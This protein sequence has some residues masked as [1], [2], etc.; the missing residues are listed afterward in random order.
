[1]THAS[2]HNGPHDDFPPDALAF[3]FGYEM[4]TRIVSDDGAVGPSEQAFLDRHFP[5]AAFQAHGFHDASGHVTQRWHDA[6]GEALL[7]VP[8]FPEADRLDLLTQLWTAAM[9]DDHLHPDEQRSIGH[10]ARLLNLPA[11]K[12]ADWL[13]HLGS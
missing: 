8:S 7:E 4:A 11:D 12:V 5:P 3:A 2:G 10:A 1:M 9:A 6:L 13:K